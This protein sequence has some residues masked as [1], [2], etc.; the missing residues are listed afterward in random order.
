MEKKCPQCRTENPVDSRFCK[1]CGNSFSGDP[2]STETLETPTEVLARGSIFAG[3]Y[4]IIEALGAGG[5]GQVYRVFDSSIQEEVALKLIKPEI[6]TNKRTVERFRNELKIA[7]K[8][9]HKN[10]CRMYDLNIEDK[11]LYITM[12]YVP[13]EDLKSLICRTKHLVIDTAASIAGQIADGLA[14]AHRLGII[15]R[16][17]KS[18]NIMVDKNGQAKIM[19]FGIAQTTKSKGITQIGMTVGTPEYMSPEQVGGAQIDQRTDLYSLGVILYEMVTGVLP[20][21]GN[22]ASA[23]G[24]K[25]QSEIPVNPRELNTHVPEALS[26][27]I[28]KCMAK[29]MEKRYRRAEEIRADLEKVG[30]S[31][32][33]TKGDTVWNNSIAVLPFTNL[34]AD[35]EQEYF[36]DGIAEEIIN[37]LA[38]V[39]NLRVVARTSA[40]AFKN[41]NV[42]V[43]EIGRELHVK[44]ILEG[45]VRKSGNRIRLLAQLINVSDG[46]HMWS[47]KYDRELDDVFAVQDEI[48]QAILDNL[49]VTLLGK[50]KKTLAKRYPENSEA[51]ILYLKG[52]YFWNKRTEEAI[53][54]SIE[55]FKEGIKQEPLSALFYAGLSDA[56]H[57]LGYY[58]FLPGKDVYRPAI[59]AVE[60]ALE[61]NESLG[62]AQASLGCIRLF[63]DWDLLAAEDAL[64]KAIHFNPNYAS[65]HHWFSFYL[66]AKG[67]HDE[68]WLEMKRAQELDPLSVVISAAAGWILYLAGDYNRAEQ[69]CL[70]AIELDPNYNVSHL[71][72][73]LIFLQKNMF[74]EAISEFQKAR[75]LIKDDAGAVT[76]LGI[77][78]VRSGD[79]EKAAKMMLELKNLSNTKYVPHYYEAAIFA[80]LGQKT[81]AIELLRKAYKERTPWLVFIKIWPIFENLNSEPEFKSLLAE[82]AI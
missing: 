24:A 50:K 6:A 21:I 39:E 57:S 52:R 40:F 80:V 42:N 81:K 2:V 54:K 76:Y 27:I 3:R 28:L 47:E 14:E 66:T 78:Y 16:D 8:I 59:T 44:T 38:H 11:A 35:K 67:L 75:E 58:N 77:A 71:V 36:C 15:H 33:E 45:S 55:Y 64:K 41:K 63:Y 49:K 25:H 19:D 29:N 20:F 68:A 9:T 79:N 48:T 46:F 73:G 18:N 61:F 32:I 7:R 60:K 62:E 4:E 1:S 26:R 69:Q 34:S 17:L 23:V 31:I 5:M 74:S 12:E 82:I 53:R 22:T 70:R 51:Y 65:A 43:I 72:C 56:Y 30:K 13:G 37:A 10:V